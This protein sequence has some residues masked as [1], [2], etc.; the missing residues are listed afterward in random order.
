VG[1]GP[2]ADS[3]AG[4]DGLTTAELA[5]RLRTPALVCLPEVTSALDEIHR[6][7]AEGAPA[8]T[9]VLADRQTAGRGRLGR[10][11]HSP[12]GQGIWLGYLLR[13]AAPET[14]VLALRAGLA[15]ARA[16]QAVGARPR[17]KWPN[18]V[19]LDDRKLAGVLC[20]AKW[21]RGRPTWV[22]LGIGINVHGPLAPELAAV[23][24]TLD[25]AAPVGRI[26]LLAGLLPALHALPWG[27]DLTPTECAA[28]AELDW[29]LGRELIE[30]VRGR[31][32]GIAPSGELLVET[33]SGTRPV[34][35]GT[36]RLRE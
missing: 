34:V 6:L 19:M 23:A 24:A 3:A 11:W 25:Q 13:P 8:G 18:D 36:V 7:A 22:A 12:A 27:G 32:G 16:A 10:P 33:E 20:E 1:Q 17:L 14:G 26:D 4:Y 28:L 31:A 30:P 21:D 35:S 5:A 2:G 29:L 9:A 15:V